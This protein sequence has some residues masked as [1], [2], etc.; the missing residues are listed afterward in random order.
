MLDCFDDIFHIK[1]W[2]LC[3]FIKFVIR[4]KVMIIIITVL[5]RCNLFWCCR[6]RCRYPCRRNHS[7]FSSIETFS[8]VDT[9]SLAIWTTKKI[10]SIECAKRHRSP[11]TLMLCVILF[12]LVYHSTWNDS[13]QIFFPFQIIFIKLSRSCSNRKKNCKSKEA[14]CL[15]LWHKN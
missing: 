7:C 6:R 2:L 11:Y 8:K 3:L 13:F 4:C 12:I 9:I 10:A 1:L 5:D 14:I 15:C